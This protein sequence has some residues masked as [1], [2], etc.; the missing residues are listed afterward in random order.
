MEAII[1]KCKE[2]Y[3]PAKVVVVIS[4]NPDAPALEKARKYGVK[5]LYIPPGEKKTVLVGKAEEEYIRT[6]KEHKVDYVLLAGFMRVIKER[7]LS[8]FEGRI[9]NI[10]PSL[11]PSFPGLEAQRQAV[12][13]GVK[14]SG[15]TVHFVTKDVDAGPIILQACVPVYDDDTPQT[16]AERI[17]KEEHRIYPEAVK[18]LVEGRLVLE[19]RRVKIKK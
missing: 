17:L 1:K 19:G 13:Y 11:L 3:I 8:E 2:G 5:A 14:F 18:L 4:D 15:C 12:E 7:F 9:L 16:L 6:L 10:H